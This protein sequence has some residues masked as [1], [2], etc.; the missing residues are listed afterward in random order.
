M[1]TTSIERAVF[2]LFAERGFEAT[3]L[4]DIAEAVG[5]GRRTLARYYPS[6]ND[7]PWGRFDRTI[8]SFRLTLAEMPPEL[9]LWEAVQRGVVAFDTFPASANPSHGE[10]MGLI[11]NTPALQAH[12]VLRY[13][14]WRAVIAG[15]VGAR[16]SQPPTALLPRT[17]AQVSLG[18]AVAAYEV[19]LAE[20]DGDLSVVL[21][22]TM[23]A[24]R[25]YLSE[26]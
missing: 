18:L 7:I 19:W 16:T 1:R 23:V 11:L 13:A 17:V 2:R 22:D 3:T 15:Y 24:L 20:P 5:I 10:R 26:Q 12:S 6:K 25:G 8:E 21:A 4:D 14:E 9:P